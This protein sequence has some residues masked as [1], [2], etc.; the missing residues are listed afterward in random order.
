MKL[1]L[2]LFL[3][4]GTNLAM[5]QEELIK[6][7]RPVSGFKSLKVSGIADVYITKGDQEKVDIEVN[8]K[9][10]NER[11]KVE[12]VNNVLII[13]TENN[14]EKRYDDFNNVK[15]KVYITYKQLI[16]VSGSGATKVNSE[17]PI[18]SDKFQIK[19]SGANNSKL[20]LDVKDLNIEISGAVNLNLSG[21]ADL[22]DIESS[23]ASN[24]KA[25]ELITQNL[26]AKTSGVSNIFIS[27]EKTL[28]VDA[29]GLSNITYDGNAVI[30]S[31]EV[32]KMANIRKRNN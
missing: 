4:L 27:A 31:K 20:S 1:N 17:Q 3:L 12:V 6:E 10:Y 19:L 21:K 5:A 9:R 8:N 32:S 2:V 22:V 26:R 30:K 29:S 28:E 14:N 7:S 13:R 15:L 18:V 16:S 23:G 25:Y 24:L 11:L